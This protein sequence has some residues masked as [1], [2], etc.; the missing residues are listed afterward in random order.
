MHCLKDF[1]S[2]LST[3]TSLCVKL[4]KE[5]KTSYISPIKS[6]SS[7]K[8]SKTTRTSWRLTWPVGSV[9][10]SSA[11]SLKVIRVLWPLMSQSKLTE[12]IRQ[13]FASRRASFSPSPL[14]SHNPVGVATVVWRGRQLIS[15]LFKSA[16]WRVSWRLTIASAIKSTWSKGLMLIRGNTAIQCGRFVTQP[17][18]LS[19]PTSILR[20]KH[21]VM[22]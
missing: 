22:I 19:I 10:C 17:C 14:T 12:Q 1:S 2:F 11:R 7:Q 6:T 21:S 20:M 15:S 13:A 8:L 18:T 3:R 5:L 4:S 9:S 16:T